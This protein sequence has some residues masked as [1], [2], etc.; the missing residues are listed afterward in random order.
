MYMGGKREGDSKSKKY[1]RN[2]PWERER[3]ERLSLGEGTWEKRES[4]EGCKEGTVFALKVG[5]DGGERKSEAVLSVAPLDG[6]G[7]R[8]GRNLVKAGAYR[9]T[10]SRGRGEKGT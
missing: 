9:M 4:G 8:G 2:W 10:F 3:R 1:R 6:I 5:E 7:H